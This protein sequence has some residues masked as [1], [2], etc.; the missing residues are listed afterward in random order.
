[1]PGEHETRIEAAFT[2]QSATFEQEALNVAFTSG[3]PWLIGLIEPDPADRV[4]DVAGGTGLVARALAPS[5]TR[6]TVLDATEAMLATG[7]QQAAAEGRTDVEFVHGDAMALPFPEAAFSLVVTRFSLHHFAD[8]APMLDEMVRVTSAGGR[9]VVKDLVSDADLQVAAR[10]D[11][12]E[13][14]RDDSHVSM[15]TAGIV[16]TWLEQHGLEATRVEQK[17]ID[18]P[19]EPWLEQSVTPA[20]RAGAVRALLRAELDGGDVTGMRPHL[21]DGELWF[22]QTWET[23]VAR[24]P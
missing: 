13:R 20:D 22:H 11:E 23:T 12:I 21:E 14:L 5:V 16:R 10:Q 2:K 18:R 9:L 6:V 7:R 24:R 8:P 1:M 19:L 15:P 17:V 3:L 4:L